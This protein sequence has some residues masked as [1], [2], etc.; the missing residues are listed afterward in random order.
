MLITA[1]DGRLYVLTDEG[2]VGLIEANPK[3]FTPAGSFKLPEKSTMPSTIPTS[4]DGKIWSHPVVANS[5]LHLRDHELIFCFE[6][7]AK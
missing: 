3:E 7:K 5:R 4:K 6:V 2:E 1:A